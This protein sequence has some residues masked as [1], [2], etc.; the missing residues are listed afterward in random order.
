M[1]PQKRRFRPLFLYT[2]VAVWTG[3]E[4]YAIYAIRRLTFILFRGMTSYDLIVA[5]LHFFTPLTSF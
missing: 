5:L 4:N 1:V 3:H 2:N